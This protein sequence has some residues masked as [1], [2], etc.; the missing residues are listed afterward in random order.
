[1]GGV[2]FRLEEGF[3][4]RARRARHL[5]NWGASQSRAKLGRGLPGLARSAA[6]E[7]GGN[8]KRSRRETLEGDGGT[9]PWRVSMERSDTTE[10][11][12]S[13]AFHAEKKR[14][15]LVRS[16]ALGDGRASM[17]GVG[18]WSVEEY[19][20]APLPVRFARPRRGINP[21]S[22]RPGLSPGPVTLIFVRHHD[23]YTR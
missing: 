15:D 14:K 11:F 9:A 23:G 22:K 13:K 16:A 21:G 12:S 20:R 4:G 8:P 3:L 17:G 18:P 19:C 10:I 1:L 6:H 2:G 5:L 7:D